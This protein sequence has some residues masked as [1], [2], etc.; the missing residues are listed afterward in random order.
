MKKSIVRIVSALVL[1]AALVLPAAKA[2]AQYINGSFIK[3]ANLPWLD[4]HYSYYLGLDPHHTDYGVA[5]N[6]AKMLQ[7]FKDMRAMNI[8][9]VRLWLNQG[10]QGCTLDSNGRVTGVTSTYWTNL[11]DT[12]HSA[13]LAG[14]QLYLTLNGG[15]ADFITDS[16]KQSAYINIVLKPMVARYR[17]N[18]HCFAIDIMN[19]IDGVVGGPD[20]NYGS[21]PTWSQAQSMVR[22]FANAIHS[23]D[24]GRKCSCSVGWH[25]WNNV[26]YMKGCNLD[27]YDFH[28][29][30]DAPS[31]PKASSLGMDR[32]IYIGE[33][34][35]STNSWSDSIQ[36]SSMSKA[37]S[38]AKANG[39]AGVGIW[40]YQYAGCTDKFSMINSNGN[41]RPVC[42]TIK[43]F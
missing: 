24:S 17:G 34:G 27:F 16:A 35:Q 21:G 25:T 11:D 6:S 32:P 9:V 10:D 30:N 13:G 12:M 22:N 31:F 4:G 5:Y 29:Y 42:T 8:T 18:S 2:Q 38:S 3:G 39:Y 37:L 19:E 43:N 15:R 14:V 23:A 7:H 41:W 40:A 20:G 28:I 1:L 36:N 26:H 33:C